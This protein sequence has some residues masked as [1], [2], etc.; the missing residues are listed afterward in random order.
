MPGFLAAA[1]AALLAVLLAGCSADGPSPPPGGGAVRGADKGQEPVGTG[2]RDGNGDGDGDVDRKGNRDRD[3]DRDGKGDGKRERGRAVPLPRI[4]SSP[5]LP[6][7]AHEV[8][9]AADGSGFALLAQCVPEDPAKSVKAFCKQYVAVLDRGAASWVLRRSPLPD[10][11]G[12]SGISA[13]LQVLGPARAWIREHG[14]TQRRRTWFTADGGRSW[15]AGDWKAHGTVTAIPKGAVLSTECVSSADPEEQEC[16]R[17]RMAVLSPKD[18]RRW[19]LAQ[20]PPLDMAP[21]YASAAEPDGSWW[22]SGRDPASGAVAVAVSRDSGRHWAVSPLPSPTKKP[23]REVVVSVGQDAVY[24]AETGSLDPDDVKNGLRALHRSLDRGRTWERM[25]TTGPE[26][27]PRTLLGHV[28]PGRGGDLVLY[29]EQDV[30]T[31]KDGGRTFEQTDFRSGYVMRTPLGFMAVD[32]RCEY[33]ISPD[34]V[35][36][37]VFRLACQNQP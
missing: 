14:E 28:V 31:S 20:G 16:T 26:R 34:G 24:A 19:F 23:A 7:W 2:T 11:H 35:R 10:V 17:H 33:R 15:R 36:W 12:D 8:R 13:E 22:V 6:G 32:S 30:Y 25:W 5:G 1:L 9:F 3:G 4:P 21:V 27:E 29:G 18:G 37:T